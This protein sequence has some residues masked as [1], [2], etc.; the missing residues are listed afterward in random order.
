MS[1]IRKWAPAIALFIG[2]LAVWEG[3]VQVFDIKG[4]ILPAPSA[5]AQ[6]FSEEWNELLE[7]SV[8]TFSTALAGLA[9]GTCIRSPRR[10]GGHSMGTNSRRVRC[11]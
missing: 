11:L 8:G 5:I 6:A 1:R 10:F 3:L 4:F 7:A 2:G 9:V